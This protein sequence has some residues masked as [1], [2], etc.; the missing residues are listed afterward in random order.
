MAVASL[1]LVVAMGGTAIAGSRLVNGDT[2]IKRNSLSGNR[3]RVHTVTGKQIDLS[4]LGKVRTASHADAATLSGYAAHAGT[5]DDA[6]A[7]GGSPAN[8]FSRVIYAHVMANGTVDVSESKGITSAEVTL[9]AISAYC[10]AGLP[11]EP[12]GGS[13]TIDYGSAGTGRSE[14]AE[15]QISPTGTALDCHANEGVEVSTAAF[16]SS[17]WTFRPEPFYIVLYGG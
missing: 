2:L 7:L 9:R 13:A 14:I 1:A 10:F 15:L 5:A 16:A 4:R 11:F 3:L 6:N 12:R 8:G 17:K